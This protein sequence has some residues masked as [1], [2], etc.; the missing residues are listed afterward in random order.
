MNADA[1]QPFS[2]ALHEE[3]KIPYGSHE[4]DPNDTQIYETYA[5]SAEL[6]DERRYTSHELDGDARNSS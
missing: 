4:L 1:D 2:T 5:S 6:R 3:L